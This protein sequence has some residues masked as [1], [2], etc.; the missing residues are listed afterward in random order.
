MRVSFLLRL[1]S[2]DHWH[3][4]AL[5]NSGEVVGDIRPAASAILRYLAAMGAWLFLFF[6]GICYGFP[7][8]LGA[9]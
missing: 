9:D 3:M 7:S 1:D 5:M 4:Q 8:M 2:M 6:V